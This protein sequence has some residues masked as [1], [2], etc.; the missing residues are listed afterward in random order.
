[1]SQATTPSSRRPK[2]VPNEE[3]SWRLEVF[4]SACQFVRNGPEMYTWTREGAITWEW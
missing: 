3:V 2:V 4:A 1:M